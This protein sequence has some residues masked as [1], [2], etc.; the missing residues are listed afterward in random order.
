VEPP[1]EFSRPVE[2]PEGPR[3][4]TFRTVRLSPGTVPA[5]R[6]YFC[7]HFTRDLVWRDE[8]RHH[9]NGA[10]GVARAVVA[11][12]DPSVLGTLFVSMFGESAV[13]RNGSGCSLAVGLSRFDVVTPAALAEEFGDAVPTGDGRAEYMAALTIRT[14]SLDLAADALGSG[15]IGGV[16]RNAERLVV[17]AA[18]TFGVT[19][20]FRG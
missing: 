10:V 16:R 20:E 17:P 7:H 15:G 13:R 4:A 8:W 12:R 6:L 5:G 3:D 1:L 9:A 18:E 14:R 11:A 19:L 2:L